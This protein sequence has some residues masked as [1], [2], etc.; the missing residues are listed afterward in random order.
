MRFD[1]LDKH[2]R[3]YETA[4]DRCVMPNMH[5]VARLDG[6]G[7]SSLTKDLKKPFDE[8]FNYRMDVVTEAL[9]QCGFK[10][11]LGYH[12]SDEISLLFAIDDEL[13]NRKVRKLVSVLASTAA[14][15]FTKS[16]ITEQ[17]IA[18]DCRLSELP[19]TTL[20]T[21]YFRW[22]VADSE[23][24]ALNGYCY[25]TL[26]EQGH[27]TKAAQKRLLHLNKEQKIKLLE[28]LGIDFNTI[29]QWQRYGTFYRWGC[30]IK[31]G[32]NPKTQQ[33]SPCKRNRLRQQ[34]GLFS[35]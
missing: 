35:C 25:W 8:N 1:E 16:T 33:E 31:M 12:Q 6:R 23:R 3:V 24:N 5:I 26:R 13:F 17:P 18:F 2:M 11:Q 7:F 15:V 9:M 21:D 34:F 30:E 20:V 10:V 27:S 19:N 28:S 22:R 4:H 29:P 32:F 14:S